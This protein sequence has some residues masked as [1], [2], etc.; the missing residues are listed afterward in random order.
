MNSASIHASTHQR[1]G[2]DYL[3]GDNVNNWDIG[4]ASVFIWGVGLLPFKDCFLS[5]RSQTAP[6]HTNTGTSSGG[7]KGFHEQAPELHAISAILSTGPVSPSDGLGGADVGLLMSLC[8]SDGLLLKPD[9]PARTVDAQWLGAVF[10]HSS[11]GGSGGHHVAPSGKALWTT[12]VVHGGLTWG[13]VFAAETSDDWHGTPAALN[14]PGGANASAGVAW[15]RPKHASSGGG[16]EEGAAAA[17]AGRERVYGIGDARRIDPA[18]I[19]LTPFSAAAPLVVSATGTSYGDF[20]LHCTAPTLSNGM[21][22][23]GELAKVVSVAAARFLEVRAHAASVSVRL[24]G[25][26]GE[27]VEVYYAKSA[28]SAVTSAV[29]TIGGGGSCTLVL[30]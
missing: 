27:V 29:C 28:T 24:A 10:T 15:L 7:F 21:I 8:R 18:V 3:D 19:A 20:A 30:K 13:Y 2:G 17:T 23:L 12:A 11:G 4:A 26:A 1:L 22:L 9:K 16:S 5:N 14:L 25:V 6:T